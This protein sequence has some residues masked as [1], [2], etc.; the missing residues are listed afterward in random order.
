MSVVHFLCSFVWDYQT[1]WVLL[2]AVEGNN[3]QIPNRN[4]LFLLILGC[5]NN[6][7][8]LKGILRGGITETK[9]GLL[10]GGGNI[11]GQARTVLGQAQLKLELE[12]YFPAFKICCIKLIK[13]VKLC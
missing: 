8:V 1:W 7:L 9:Y 2:P 13:L 11:K 5:Y 4:T 3:S 12:L 6:R 10:W